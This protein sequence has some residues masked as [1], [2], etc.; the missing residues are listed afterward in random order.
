MR[1][2]PQAPQFL[3]A[4]IVEEKWEDFNDLIEDGG[5]I[6]AQVFMKNLVLQALGVQHEEPQVQDVVFEDEMLLNSDEDDEDLF[7]LLL[8]ACHSLS[9]FKTLN[10]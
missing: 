10:P 7:D 6:L 1:L 9:C 8:K 4:P 5:G 3:E 2:G